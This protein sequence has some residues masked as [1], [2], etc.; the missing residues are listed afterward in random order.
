[1]DV[2]GYVFIQCTKR[3]KGKDL[4]ALPAAWSPVSLRAP[5]ALE[6]SI[7]LQLSHHVM[8]VAIADMQYM[9]ML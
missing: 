8:Q 3:D 6:A 7:A 4:A 5:P 9:F 1:M 2:S